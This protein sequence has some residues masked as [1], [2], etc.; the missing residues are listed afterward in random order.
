M[1]SRRIPEKQPTQGRVAEAQISVDSSAHHSQIAGMFGAFAKEANRVADA[2]AVDAAKKKAAQDLQQNPNGIPALQKGQTISAQAYN[3]TTKNLYDMQADAN[4]QSTLLQFADE[5]K[6]SPLEYEKVSREYLNT[7]AGKLNQV[8]PALAVKAQ[9][10]Y[11]MMVENMKLSIQENADARKVKDMTDASNALEVIVD[12]SLEQN[13]GRMYHKDDDGVSIS[14]IE[15][16]LSDYARH[17]RTQ[18][19]PKTGEPLHSEAK[20][21]AY[22]RNKKEYATEQ[23]LRAQLPRL[24]NSELKNWHDKL[25]EDKFMVKAYNPEKDGGVDVNLNTL[26]DADRKNMLLNSVEQEMSSRMSGAQQFSYAHKIAQEDLIADHLAQAKNSGEVPGGM[27]SAEYAE[28]NGWAPG[29]YVNYRNAV[30]KHMTEFKVNSL[31][32]QLSPAQE[33]AVFSEAETLA[34]NGGNLAA[35]ADVGLEALISASAS[36]KAALEGNG[37]T[38]SSIHRYVPGVKDQHADYVELAV[39][40]SQEGASEED[41]VNASKAFED[42]ATTLDN[43]YG[44]NNVPRNMRQ[45]LTPAEERD[46]LSRFPNQTEFSTDPKPDEPHYGAAIVGW[47]QG[48]EQQYGHR[49]ASVVRQLKQGDV[50]IPERALDILR[51]P[52]FNINGR[53]NFGEAIAD[54]KNLRNFFGVAKT[55]DIEDKVSVG[56]EEFIQSIP[57]GQAGRMTVTNDY[58]ESISLL[59]QHYIHTGDSE[60]KAIERAIGDFTGVF[61]M[62]DTSRGGVTSFVR[63]TTDDPDEEEAMRVGIQNLHDA[64]SLFEDSDLEFYPLGSG[65]SQ[66][67]FQ[68]RENYLSGFADGVTKQAVLRTTS[69][70]EHVQLYYLNTPVQVVGKDRGVREFKVPVGSIASISTNTGARFADLSSTQLE[71][72]NAWGQFVDEDFIM[73]YIEDQPALRYVDKEGNEFV[74]EKV[75]LFPQGLNSMEAP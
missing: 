71:S 68:T 28:A 56:L 64:V 67:D 22:V 9:A 30:E 43:F 31:V 12:N 59:T 21:A 54:Q 53:I 61:K 63:I 8:D 57:P 13:I 14:V 23:G 33:A 20:V 39:K 19:H 26:L 69:D 1:M 15:T 58:R 4:I 74:P 16:L 18:F 72:K 27:A 38:M 73:Q 41:L 65:V 60:D 51:V 42:Y 24:N 52:K 7:W 37:N 35:E 66:K 5:H 44:I 45:Y 6:E 11:G 32:Y 36:K 17:L 25:R 49:T 47:V 10:K 48:I 50:N 75:R 29:K 62:V 55:K 3:A 40:V 2:Q 46:W 70:G 34:A